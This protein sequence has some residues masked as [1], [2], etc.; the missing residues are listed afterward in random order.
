MDFIMTRAA[1]D[2]ALC[3]PP[4]HASAAA[5][6]ALVALPIEDVADRNARLIFAKGVQDI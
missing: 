6:G 3:I 1:T 2:R 4:V 5:E